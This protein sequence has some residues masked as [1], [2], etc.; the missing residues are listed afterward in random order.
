M[1]RL[2]ILILLAGT[3]LLGYQVGRMPGTSDLPSW[4]KEAWGRVS[5]ALAQPNAPPGAATQ[6]ASPPDEM[7]VSIN[8]RTYRIGGK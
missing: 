3:F 5:A 2:V 6:P 1:R 4:M 8:G 7:T